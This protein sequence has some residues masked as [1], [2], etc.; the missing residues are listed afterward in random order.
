M[1]FNL[2]DQENKEIKV[3]FQIAGKVI[4]NTNIDHSHI[5]IQGLGN[6]KQ[7]YQAEIFNGSKAFTL[8]EGRYRISLSLPFSSDNPETLRR[9]PPDPIEVNVPALDFKEIDLAFQTEKSPPAEKQKKPAVTANLAS[10]DQT[11]AIP[12]GRAIIGDAA[13]EEDIN[14]LPSKIVTISAFAIGIYEV[15]NAQYAAWLNQALKADKISYVK[16]ADDRGQVVDTTGHLLFKT[17]IA[18]PYSQITVQLHSLESPTFLP[19]PGK[20][21]Y[22]VINVSWFGAMA[23]CADHHARLP[24]EAEWEKAASMEPEKQGAPLKKYRYGFGSNTI[25]RTWANYKDDIRPLQSFRVLTTPVGFYN[26][27]N[28]LPL[29]AEHKMQ[30]RTHLAK[31]PYGAFDMS[32]NVWEWVSDWYDDSYYAGMSDTDPQG[33]K[34]GILKVVKGGC[35]DS[36][37]DGVRVSERLGLLPEYTDAYTGFRIVIPEAER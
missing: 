2:N 29:T 32:G 14:E 30:Q 8:P 31:S 6:Q 7:T 25:D 4:I 21:S 35:Y 11:A 27:V 9:F 19:L 28:Y 22:P 18:D 12:A 24:T 5:T 16:E 36:L 1:R 13:S 34:T 15:T 3:S 33:P 20:D 10:G 37:A 23:Y 26:G 17:S